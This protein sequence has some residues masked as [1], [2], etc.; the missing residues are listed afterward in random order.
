MKLF[1]P[2][3]LEEITTDAPTG[4][5][6]GTTEEPVVEPT[7]DE[8][9]PFEGPEWLG[10]LPEELRGDK[11]LQTFK[12]VDDLAKSYIHARKTIGNNRVPIPDDSATQD[13]WNEFYKKM[14]L[15]EREKYEIKFGDAKY[16]DDFKKGF[17]DQAHTNGILPKQAEGLFNYFNEQVQGA[18]TEASKQ[19]Q[20]EIAAEYEQL[21]KDWGSGYE[22]K[23]KIAQT[24]V[25]TFA[26]EDMLN[27]LDQS[28]L[29]HDTKLIRLFAQ[30]GEKLNEDTFERNTI[31]HLGMTKDEAVEKRDQIMGNSDHPYWN[32]DHMNH[33]QAVEEVLKYNKIIES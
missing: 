33:K 15:P 16:S 12:G 30:I 6:G 17:L 2:F 9:A 10:S 26:D 8:P 24:A 20:E 14:G 25:Q 29:A 18:N 1:S 7:T 31:K 5:T 32:H 27:Y 3:K 11:S 4:L 28:G 21:Q 13:D 19:A 23:L 22:K